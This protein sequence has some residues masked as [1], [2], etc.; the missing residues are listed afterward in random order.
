MGFLSGFKV[1]S[2]TDAA[3]D[4]VREIMAG[5]DKPIAGL[6]VGVLWTSLVIDSSRHLYFAPFDDWREVLQTPGITFV[7][8]QYGDQSGAIAHARISRLYYGADDPKRGYRRYS[9]QVFPPR[10]TVTRGVLAEEC[11]RLVRSFFA[12][13]RR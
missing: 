6:K 13:L 4:R 9:E 10:T 2:L 1:M 12:A 5:S 11:E 8:L 3:A 7:N